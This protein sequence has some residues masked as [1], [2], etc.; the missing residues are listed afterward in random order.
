MNVVPLPEL[1]Y[2]A[3]CCRLGFASRCR[4]P[5]PGPARCPYLFA[6]VV[7]NGSKMRARAWWPSM[8]HAG[9]GDCHASRTG[10]GLTP[11]G[12]WLG[13]SQ[14]SSMDVGRLDAQLA[15]LSGMAS[16]AF[17]TK[18]MMICSICPRIGLAEVH[19]P[20]GRDVSKLTARCFRPRSA[21]LSCARCPNNDLVEARGPARLEQLLAAER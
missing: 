8:P 11:S 1:A 16:R 20:S 9:I 5:W 6:L 12:C 21:D 10:P 13:R 2:K 17:T 4:T 19:R 3:K 18:L 15:A 7:K 14:E